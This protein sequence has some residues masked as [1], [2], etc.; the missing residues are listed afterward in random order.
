MLWLA[1]GSV[2]VAWVSATVF[3]DWRAAGDPQRALFLFLGVFPLANALFDA[4]SYAATLALLRRGLRSRLPLVWGLADL[5]FACVLFLALGLA[6]TALVHGL[7]TLAGTPLLDLGALFAGVREAP[8]A[9]VWLYLMLFSTLVPTALHGLLSLLGVQGL[10]PRLLRAPVADWM[11]KAGAD[12]VNAIRAPF[13]LGTIWTV[14]LLALCAALWGLVTLGDDA[15]RW[16]GA[17]YFDALL[18]VAHVQLGA[19]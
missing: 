18:R 4:L 3:I 13:A 7:N 12:P 10:W 9:Y 19:L 17:W 16:L 11:R 1:S 15:A 6:L 5:A 14:P 2:F 8:G